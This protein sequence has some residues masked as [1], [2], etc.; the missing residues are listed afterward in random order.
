MLIAVATWG[1]IINTLFYVYFR[2]LAFFEETTPSPKCFEILQRV[3]TIQL[4]E[5]LKR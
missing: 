5:L 4:L 1:I 2:R 3:F